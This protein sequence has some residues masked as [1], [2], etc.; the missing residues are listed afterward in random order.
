LGRAPK[1]SDGL[2][3]DPQGLDSVH[4]VHLLVNKRIAKLD[5]PLK[6]CVHVFN[7]RWK[8]GH[9]LDIVIP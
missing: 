5:G 6:V 2:R 4:H 3:F 7:D 9:R 8:F 1:R